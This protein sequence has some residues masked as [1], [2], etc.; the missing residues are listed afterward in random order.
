MLYTL[1]II[2][3]YPIIVPMLTTYPG[4]T[5]ELIALTLLLFVQADSVYWT[6]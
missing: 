4:D 2:S 6:S 1:D 5:W 3:P